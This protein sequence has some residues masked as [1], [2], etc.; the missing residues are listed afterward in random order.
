M[1]LRQ[2]VRPK[3]VW[4][5]AIT[6]SDYADPQLFRKTSPLDPTRLRKL[7]EAVANLKPSVIGVDID[8]SDSSGV[9]PQ[10]NVP[11][12]WGERMTA[13]VDPHERKTIP[14]L[15]NEQPQPGTN[16]IGISALPADADRSV[17]RYRRKIPIQNASIDS[18][19]WSVTKAFCREIVSH[20]MS[21]DLKL[22]C[23]KILSS[24]SLKKYQRPL[25]LSFSEPPHTEARVLSASDVLRMSSAE[26]WETNPTFRDGLV[27]VGGTFALSGDVSY[28]T[29][30]GTRAGVQL[31]SDAI[32]TELQGRPITPLNEVLMVV[33][34]IAGGYLLAAW[35]YVSRDWR[36]VVL[37]IATVPLLAIVL[38]FLAFSSLAYWAS[39][40]PVLVGVLLHE[41]HEHFN[42]YR[43]LIKRAREMEIAIRRLQKRSRHR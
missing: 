42:H 20:S 34:E 43:T 26:G 14:V 11:I 38:S 24:E 35:H 17:R 23:E 28:N 19:P 31:F 5:V 30:I 32:E 15:G 40:V 29:P 6:D 41:A 12:I 10:T 39:F 13:D 16:E 21:P 22:Q 18:L 25:L 36:A 3:Y 33:F 37:R 1:R 8:T 7:L 9:R 2:P 27:M 4:L